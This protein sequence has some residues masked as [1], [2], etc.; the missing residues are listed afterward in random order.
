MKEHEFD[1][2]LNIKT[3]EKQAG[4]GKTLHYHRYEPTPYW[5]L[6]KLFDKYALDASDRVVDFG[7]GKGRLIFYINYLF[8]AEVTGIELNEVLVKE[9]I[10]NRDSY[11]KITKKN[12]DKITFHCCKAEE[13]QI[14]PLEN[15]F[16]FFNPFSLPI[17]IRILNNILISVENSK[18]QVDLILYYPS[19]E[20]IYYLEN[21]TVFE[22]HKEV[23]LPELYDHDSNE[24]FLIYHLGY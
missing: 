20:Y 15:R 8:N 13:Y 17:F 3:E 1:E 10:I 5:A 7:S 16:Y 6:G 21:S 14:K 9:A 11:L 12:K 2:R 18:R 23:V 19:E 4:F 24:R 22:L